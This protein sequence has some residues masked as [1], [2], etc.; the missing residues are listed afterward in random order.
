MK[1]HLLN[2][3]D[4]ISLMDGMKHLPKNL[5]NFEECY[6]NL[7]TRI[8]VRKW[9]W[10]LY[11]SIGFIGLQFIPWTF[12]TPILW[13]HG[14]A[15]RVVLFEAGQA[16]PPFLQS[17]GM[18]CEFKVIFSKFSF[19]SLQTRF[20]FMFLRTTLLIYVLSLSSSTSHAHLSGISRSG[21]LDCDRRANL[22]SD[23]DQ[24]SPE[25]ISG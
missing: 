25:N 13:S 11:K 24:G 4:A 3:M 9:I 19:L 21:P 15:D 23:V 6:M 12:Q 18:S 17:A 16:G 22:S 8:G 14:V 5:I 2:K 7:N 10:N 1:R 20:S